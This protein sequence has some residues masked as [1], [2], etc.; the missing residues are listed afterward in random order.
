MNNESVALSNIHSNFA[1][2]FIKEKAGPYKEHLQVVYIIRGIYC[3]MF[4]KG[5]LRNGKELNHT[6]NKAKLTYEFSN[7]CHELG[8]KHCIRYQV[9]GYNGIYLYLNTWDSNRD[10]KQA[11]NYAATKEAAAAVGY[12]E[13]ESW[14]EIEVMMEH[15]DYFHNKD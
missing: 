15:D 14:E 6:N 8:L 5:V 1:N 9:D 3:I 13:A 7:A 12:P 2:N 4:K 11:K 10:I